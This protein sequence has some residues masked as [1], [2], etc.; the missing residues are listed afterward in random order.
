MRVCDPIV[1]K[2][3]VPKAMGEPREDQMAGTKLENIAE[4]AGRICY[5]SLGS[6]RSSEEY[7]AHILEVGHTSVYEH[8]VF[9]VHIHDDLE[10]YA[11]GLLNRPGVWV[12]KTSDGFR[13]T[14]NLRA[15]LDWLT[16]DENVNDQLVLLYDILATLAHELA[17]RVIKMPK[18]KVIAPASLVQ[19]EIPQET[20]VSYYLVGSRGFSH[21]QVRHGDWTAISQRSTRYVDESTSPMCWH[22]ALRAKKYQL[23]PKVNSTLSSITR[24]TQEGYQRLVE[25]LVADGVSRKQARGAARGV[26]PHAL[27]TEMIFTA[28]VRQW[29]WIIESRC[30]EHADAEIREIIQ[31]VADDLV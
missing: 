27:Q 20:Y 19:P 28:S 21:E 14:T 18:T 24:H 16:W 5:D 22:P 8:C 6:G 12:R 17:P 2:V 4:L 23:G 31:A 30:S 15:V 11:I 26:L 7:H 3:I 1:S 9:T 13:L 25:I 29:K 10:R